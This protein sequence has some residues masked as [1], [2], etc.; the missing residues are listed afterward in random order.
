[1]IQII[2]L[3][4]ISLVLGIIVLLSKNQEVTT[5]DSFIKI[6]IVKTISNKYVAIDIDNKPLT[7]E[8]KTK[9]EVLNQLKNE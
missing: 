9:K 4:F 5:L 7:K 8:F 1:M 6:R 2:I 3:G